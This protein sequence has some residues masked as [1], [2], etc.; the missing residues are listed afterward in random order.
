MGLLGFERRFGVRS[1]F[2]EWCKKVLRFRLHRRTCQRWIARGIVI[3][4]LVALSAWRATR[5]EAVAEA[6]AAYARSDLV[7]A[8]RRACD[9]LECWPSS[10]RAARVA[11]LSLSRLDFPEQADRYYRLAS[12]LSWDDLHHR[13]YGLVRGNHRERAI[14]AYRRILSRW[15]DDVLAMK[16]QAG[17]LI[18]R[19]QRN[20]ALKLA[21]RLIRIPEGA[22]LGYSLVGVLNYEVGEAELAVAAFEKVLALDPDLRTMPLNPDEFWKDFGIDLLVL[23]RY[24]DVRR[25]MSRALARKDNGLLMTLM[26]EA[27]QAESRLD[28]AEPCWRKAIEWDPKLPRAWFN[29]GKLALTRGRPHEAIPYLEQAARLAPESH[30]PL[31]SLSLA[32]GR[33]GRNLEAERYRLQSERIRRNASQPPRGAASPA[34]PPS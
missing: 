9:R 25:Y 8:L 15:P 3:T 33:L 32:Y 24:A 10:P 13:A 16:R 21:E 11:A 7:T 19:G 30:R 31:Y 26:G 22:E 4:G 28:E 5:P 23:G 34:S 14:Q 2:S 29:L 6:E 27:Y 20:A 1:V 18:S 12:R 17:V